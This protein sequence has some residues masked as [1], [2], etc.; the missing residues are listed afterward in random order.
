MGRS[1]A[2]GV[3]VLASCG[4]FHFDPL[5]GDDANTP[6]DAPITGEGSSSSCA[7]MP[8]CPGA[9]IPLVVGGSAG[10]SRS[11]ANTGYSGSCGGMANPEA[12]WKLDPL[13]AGTFTITV[14]VGGP[15]LIILRDGCCNGAELACVFDQPVTITRTQDQQAFLIVE[16]LQP[17]VTVQIVGN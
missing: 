5:A 4:R 2:I 17:T 11:T 16:S 3:L 14:T 12:V 15:G 1:I 8:T 9:T 10:G 7:S 13:A 6:D